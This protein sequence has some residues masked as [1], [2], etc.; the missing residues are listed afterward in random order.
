M[1]HKTDSS[2]NLGRRERTRDRI[3]A[4][5]IALFKQRG[6]AATTMDEIASAA[7]VVRATLYNHFPV[8]EA[9]VVHWLHEQLTQALG[10]LMQEAMSRRSFLA[11]V[12]TLLEASATWWEANCLFAA[13]Y[14]RYRFHEFH[15][16]E[17]DEPTSAMIPAYERL[18]RLGQESGEL[19]STVPA[20]RLASYLHS[21]TL[22]AL[23]N[24]VTGPKV[25]LAAM[26]AD[27][28]DFFMEGA[29][30]R[31]KH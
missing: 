7:D 1:I 30:V 8:K 22:C 23:I 9:I 27:A 20:E 19:S 12:A 25:A 15:Q 16:D 24:W 28:L 3:A 10:P 14:I 13:P 26:F 5:G 21:L 17:S 29:R 4:T 18:I 11:R 2:G 31:Q 6:F